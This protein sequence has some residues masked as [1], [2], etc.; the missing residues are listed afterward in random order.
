MVVQ[1][2]SGIVQSHRLETNGDIRTDD[3][4]LLAIQ[5]MKAPKIQ[6]SIW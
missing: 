5:L 1:Q 6:S 3:V 4:V 2:V